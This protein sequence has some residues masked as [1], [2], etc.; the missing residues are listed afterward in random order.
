MATG[1]AA[2]IKKR[3]AVFLLLIIGC[4]PPVHSGVTHQIT[5]TPAADRTIFI[6][7]DATKAEMILITKRLETELVSKGYQVVESPDQ[8][9]YTIRLDLIWFGLNGR[10]RPFSSGSAAGAGA[11][12]GTAAGSAVSGSV[13]NTTSAAGATGGLIG[14]GAGAVLGMFSGSSQKVLFVGNIDVSI[15]DSSKKEEK[16]LV[17]AWARVFRENQEVTAREGVAKKLALKIAALMP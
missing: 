13:L 7:K 9:A 16:T 3:F 2:M 1:A 5:V 8:A 14:F 11:A 10:P 15:T 17:S 12:A 6:Q 4:T